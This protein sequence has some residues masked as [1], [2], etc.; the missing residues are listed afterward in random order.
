M[1]ELQITDKSQFSCT[2]CLSGL[3]LL[4]HLVIIHSATAEPTIGIGS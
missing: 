1:S 4:P 3:L 2:F